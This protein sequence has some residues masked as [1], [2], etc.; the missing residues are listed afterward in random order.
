MGTTILQLE[1]VSKFYGQKLILKNMNLS[2]ESG[3]I[4]IILGGNGAGKTTLLKIMAGLSQADSGQVKRPAPEK[5]GFLGHSTF[6]YPDLSAIENLRFW[7]QVYNV[8]PVNLPYECLERT[9]L[10][11]FAAEK[12]RTFSRGMSQRLNFSRILMQSPEVLLL[13]EPFTG[14]DSQS[15][16]MMLSELINLRSNNC[17]IALVSHEPQK[18]MEISD[19]VYFLNNKKIAY[20]GPPSGFSIPD[21]PC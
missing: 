8:D 9:R 20:S 12:A 21:F 3:K 2:L 14:L 19:H 5:T 16:K 11:P 7:A 17:A 1:N 18:D 10:S 13:D 6:L 15:R 4:H